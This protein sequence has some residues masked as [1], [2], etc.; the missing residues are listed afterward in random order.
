M[1]SSLVIGRRKLQEYVSG[2][3]PVAFEVTRMPNDVYVVIL[4]PYMVEHIY[5]EKKGKVYAG[6]GGSEQIG[7]IVAALVQR[8]VISAKLEEAVAFHRV[9]EV[10]FYCVVCR[11]MRTG[12]CKASIELGGW[13]CAH[14]QVERIECQTKVWPTNG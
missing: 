4:R 12:S 6:T 1:G 11:Q 10:E 7:G 9:T 5:R 3:M 8:A 2:E 14:H 13:V